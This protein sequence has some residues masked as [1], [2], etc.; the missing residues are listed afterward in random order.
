MVGESTRYFREWVLLQRIM[1]C[2]RVGLPTTYKSVFGT[3][4]Y[5]MVNEMLLH[6]TFVK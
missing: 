1:K 5:D 2:A 3:K 4:G 6:C